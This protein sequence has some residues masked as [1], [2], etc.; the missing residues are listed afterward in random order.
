MMINLFT[1]TGIFLLLHQRKPANTGHS[2]FCDIVLVKELY[3]LF[4]LS[5]SCKMCYA[6]KET[7]YAVLTME[8]KQ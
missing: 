8:T 3:L 6:L 7:I 4:S 1:L 5:G 2:L